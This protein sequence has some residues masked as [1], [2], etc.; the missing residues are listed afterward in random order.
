MKFQ[1]L[2][3]IMRQY[4]EALD[5]HIPPKIWPV[6]RL[7]GRSFSTLTQN[8]ELEKPF[9]IKFR[10]AMIATTKHVMQAGFQAIYAYVESDEISILFSQN[11]NT[12]RRKIRKW[13]STLAGEASA[14]FTHHLGYPGVFDARICPF[15]DT[16]IIFDYFRWRQADSARNSLNAYCYW[17]LRK[18]GKT[19]RQ[20]TSVLEKMPVEQKYILLR[21]YDINYKEIPKWQRYG[22]AVVWKNIMR[23]GYNPITKKTVTTKRRSLEAITK[24]P[25]QQAYQDFI[26]QFICE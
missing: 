24:L 9:D 12:F 15:P 13:L 20:A 25:R 3:L 26:Q 7:D 23:E 10:D 21:S 16:E 19:E 6:V 4:E 8:L 17:T 18:N 22:I 14:A 2:D 5:Q 1:N 11:D